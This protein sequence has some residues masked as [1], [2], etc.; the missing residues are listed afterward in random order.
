M[1]Q[2]H[3]VCMGIED[4]LWTISIPDFAEVI[5]PSLD[6]WRKQKQIVSGGR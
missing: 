4:Q 2:M 3:T 5:I 6:A 1:R